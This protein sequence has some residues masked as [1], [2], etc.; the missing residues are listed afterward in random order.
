MKQSIRKY[1]KAAAS[2]PPGCEGNGRS[3]AAAGAHPVAS[4]GFHQNNED[5]LPRITP[6][7]WE[8]MLLLWDKGE[9]SRGQI[10]DKLRIGTASVRT[11]TA[12]LFKRPGVHSRSCAIRKILELGPGV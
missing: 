11:H 3:L 10:A 7:E 6:A 4:S 2:M 5:S 12:R 8:V 1:R 9:L